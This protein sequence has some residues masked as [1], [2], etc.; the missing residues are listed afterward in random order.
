MLQKFGPYGLRLVKKYTRQILEGLDFLHSEKIVH[1]DV[2][3]PEPQSFFSP[4]FFCFLFCFCGFLVPRRELESW[5][6]V[7]LGIQ[8]RKRSS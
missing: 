3:G 1:R 2:K 8:K 4:V 5:V 7:C 6:S